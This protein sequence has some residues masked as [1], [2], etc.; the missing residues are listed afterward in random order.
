[1]QNL[2]DKTKVKNLRLTIV[3]NE[4]YGY[5]MRKNDGHVMRSALEFDLE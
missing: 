2:K 5:V 1:M 3:L 4:R